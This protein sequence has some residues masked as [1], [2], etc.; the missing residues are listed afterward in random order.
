M[1]NLKFAMVMFLAAAALAVNGCT[2][3][4]PAPD[5]EPAT[6]TGTADAFSCTDDVCPSGGGAIVQI[7]QHARCAVGGSCNPGLAGHDV[8]GC[9]AAPPPVC[10]GCA[11]D[12]YTCTR[13]YCDSTGTCRHVADDTRCDGG[14]TC[15]ASAADGASGCYTA[16]VVSCASGCDDGVACTVD[17]CSGGV[18]RHF[19]DGTECAAGETCDATRGCVSTV[20]PPVPAVRFCPD[21]ALI[22]EQV[23]I[24]FTAMSGIRTF[25]GGT[26]AGDMG[27]MLFSSAGAPHPTFGRVVEE[28][29]TAGGTLNVHPFEGNS[30]TFDSRMANLQS[31]STA[32]DDV[33]CEARGIALQVYRSGSWVALPEGFCHFGWDTQPGVTWGVSPDPL[34]P[35]DARIGRILLNQACETQFQ[36]YEGTTYRPAR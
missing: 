25:A 29:V 34:I 16:P 32:S 33:T 28:I 20:P 10:T 12:A 35:T 6:C 11:L 27:V 2:A 36:V 3:F 7:P 15:R 4:G 9:N 1:T 8:A 21:G 19:V 31:V 23:R 17:T 26:F 22:G 30:L 5:G 13:D 14:E 18:C 24:A